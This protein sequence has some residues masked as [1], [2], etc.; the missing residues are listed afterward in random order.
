MLFVRAAN[1]GRT[2]TDLFPKEGVSRDFEALA[3]NL[4]ALYRHETPV[5]A[6]AESPRS[7]LGGI[8]RRKEPARV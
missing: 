4:L 8:F 3:D 6:A 2:V 1:V 7:L 5:P